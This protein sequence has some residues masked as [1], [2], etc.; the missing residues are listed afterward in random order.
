MALTKITNH[1]IA[2]TG[3]TAGTYGAAA[4]VPVLTIN[5]QGQITAA[6]TTAVAGVDSV[7]YSTT[8]SVLTI[9]TSDG[10][11]HSVNLQV[12]DTP[13]TPGTYGSSSQVPVIEVDQQGQVVAISTTAVAG[14]SS[15]D[16]NTST[17]VLTINTSDGGSFTEDLGVG[18]GDSP[19]FVDLTVDS[20]QL[21]GG[22]GDQG[23][24][25][26]NTDEETLDLVQNNTVLQIGQEVHVHVRNKS[27]STIP[28]GTVVMATG[29]LGA[30]GRITVAP[31]DGTSDVKY[32]IGLATEDILNGADGKVTSFG[33][34]RG[35]DTSAWN[36][37]DV[38]YA[39]T[40][41]G[42]TNVKPTEGVVNAI[43]FVIN[44]HANNGTLMVRFTPHNDHILEKYIDFVVDSGE[45][46]HVEGRVYYNEEYKALTVYNDI[47]G[48]SLQV[49]LE[50]WI[51]VYNNSGSNIPNGTPLYA[52]G[53]VGEVMTVSPA[54]ATTEAAARVIGVATNDIANNSEGVATVRGLI[55]GIDTSGLTAGHPVHL[56]PTGGFQNAAPTYPYFPVDLGGCVVSDATN[57]YIY[58]R[59]ENHTFEQLR[60]TGNTHMDGNLQIDGDLVVTGTQ[61]VVSQA[62]LN[63]DN[64]F[65]YLNSGDTIGLENTSFSGTGLNDAYFNNHYEGATTK[66]F[67]VRIDGVGTGTGGVD[68]FEW[69]TDNFS[70]TEAT[71]VDL[72]EE[73]LLSDNICIHFNATTGHTLGDTWSG[74]A[75]PVNVDS[76]WFS[77]RNTGTSGV[78]YTHM[79]IYFDVSDNKFKVVEEYDPE[80]SGTIDAGHA[81]YNAGTFVA[82][83]FEGN[84]IGNVTGNVSSI[85]NH[86]TDALSE[87]TSNLYFTDARARS[88]ITK[89]TVDALNV[90]ADTLDG[91]NSTQFLRSDAD[92]TYSGTLTLSSGSNT[93]TAVKINGN[94]GNNFIWMVG[95]QGQTSIKMYENGSNDPAYFELYRANSIQH[96][97]GSEIGEGVVFNEQ[98]LD[99]DFRVETETD[100]HTLFVN[101]SSD[102][103]GIGT[104]NPLQKLHVEG[105][106]DNTL[107][108]QDDTIASGTTLEIPAGKQVVVDHLDVQGTLDI[109]GTLATTTGGYLSQTTM[110][111]EAIAHSNGTTAAT[112]ATDGNITIPGYLSGNGGAYFGSTIDVDG[113]VVSYGT[114]NSSGTGNNTFSGNV[115]IGTPTPNAKLDV[116]GE[117][118]VGNGTDGVKL[119]WSTG[120]SAGVID[121]ADTSDTLSIRTSGTERMRIDSAGRVTTPYQ[122]AGKM[123]ITTSRAV[124]SDGKVVF[125]ASRNVRGGVVVDL[126]NNRI[127]VP[128]AGLY[129]V[130]MS[131]GS[132]S[133]SVSAGDGIYFEIRTNGSATSGDTVMSSYGGDSGEEK[134]NSFSTAIYLEAGEYIELYT[135]NHSGATANY[136]TGFL[137]LYLIG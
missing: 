96:S 119:S 9:N 71:D 42:L 104:N 73:V 54:N 127:T 3:V 31:Y 36:E 131:I 10:G 92:D 62:S 14:V 37:G 90:D 133:V 17:G 22:S 41:G 18:T 26:W 45:P 48:S 21:A 91:L 80:P 87:G 30:S 33:K 117:A 32:I 24:L 47:V 108:L 106:V 99:L 2:D 98:G 120:S 76:G 86:T 16:Y 1:V 61:S 128:V 78:G 126:T 75:A 65:V 59:I 102:N 84:L 19:T 116:V 105:M 38:L 85:N 27:G 112:I 113:D 43:A 123:Y 29:T 8:T 68:T 50:E 130:N 89:A 88:A 28:N 114:V 46:N 79:G 97:F 109:I 101:G 12:G 67:Y 20:V 39:A 132:S 56:A 55:S 118:I 115:G 64:S 107:N 72:A 95:N 125:D 63:V 4:S 60:V 23:T 121:T 135:T 94:G 93:K 70:T 34:I 52:T 134:M 110:K 58:I 124:G 57:G 103:V 44:V 5:E 122:P 136:Q 129:Q 13:I 137:D 111:T 69:S 77:N 35:I 81:S 25:S 74:T 11:S 49:G 7:T 66:T 6:S 53:A 15:T 82:D 83:T 100:Q 40:S 51:R